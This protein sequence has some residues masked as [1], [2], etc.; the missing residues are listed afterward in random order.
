MQHP[1]PRAT[2]HKRLAAYIKK[3]P[4]VRPAEV[5]RLGIPREY[6]LRLYRQGKLG[7]PS[8]GIYTRNAA[9]VTAHHSLAEVAKRYPRAV[10][11]LASAL[12]FHGLTTQV[13]FE[14]WLAVDRRARTPGGESPKLR[15]FRV[16]SPAFEAGVDIH[17]IEGVPVRIY[18]PARTVADCFKFRN[19]I[20]LDVA[21]EAL[22]DSV[23]QRK[24]TRN[25]IYEFSRLCRVANVI[26]PYMEAL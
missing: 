8:R 25:A 12:A 13:P 21:I 11:C 18:S 22:K 26:R 10:V 5:E 9:S 6:L 4:I 1:T 16:S 3:N 7:R 19:K 14:V 20:G 24:A 23:R 2:H 15:V 17:K